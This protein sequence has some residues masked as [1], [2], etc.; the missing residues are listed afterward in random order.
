MIHGFF[1]MSNVVPSAKP[2]M[3]KAAAA[4]RRAFGG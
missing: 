1:A 3:E 2:G 4:L